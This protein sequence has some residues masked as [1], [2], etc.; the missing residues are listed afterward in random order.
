MFHG[1]KVQRTMKKKEERD[2]KQ[3]LFYIF[4][5]QIDNKE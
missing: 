4:A 1:A 3:K 2:E 5:Q